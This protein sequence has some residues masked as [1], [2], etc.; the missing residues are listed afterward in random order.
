MQ[1]IFSHPQLPYLLYFFLSLNLTFFIGHLIYSMIVK[2]ESSNS[3]QIFSKLSIGLILIVFLT[4]LYW[5]SGNTIFWGWIIPFYF[6]FKKIKFKLKFEAIQIR[7]LIILQLFSLPILF[8]QYL[9][10]AKWGSFTLLPIDINN[11]AEISFYLK[12]GFECKYAALNSLDVK[13]IPSRS[14]YHYIDN[15]ITIFFNN[16]FRNTKI[17][18]I[19]IF[20]VFPIMITTFLSGLFS[21]LQNN[22]NNKYL[23][24]LVCILFL[25]F[26]PIDLNSIRE[27]FNDGS[28]LASNTVIFENVGFFFNTL[29]FSYHGQ[30][31]IPFYILVCWILLVYTKSKNKNLFVLFSFAPII[32]IGL[33]PAIIGGLSLFTFANYIK[34]K[35]LKESISSLNPIILTTV[36]LVVF[37][38]INGGY[39]IENQTKLNLFDSYLNAKGEILK[40]LYKIVYSSLFLLI[41]YFIF[42]IPFFAKKREGKIN[43]LLSITGYII[44]S[45]IAT[46]VVFEGFNSAQFLSYVLPLVNIVLMYVCSLYFKSKNI[47]AIL[48]CLLIIIGCS[49]NIK[50]TYYHT[51]NRRE[52]D[53]E[54]LHTKEFLSKVNELLIKSPNPKIG[55]FLS[56]QDFKLIPPGFWYGYYPCEFLLTFNYFQIYSLNFPNQKYSENSLSSNDFTTNHLR[57]ILPHNVKYNEYEK[58][59]PKIIKKMKI[60]YIIAKKSSRIPKTVSN[61]F[62]DSLR[63]TQSGDVIYRLF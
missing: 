24:F 40:V 58:V 33:A 3:L 1:I 14:P 43:G 15:W 35:K 11:H 44:I 21:V 46:R 42:L 18:Y 16:I 63:D 37:Y 12:N 50:R 20:V 48:Y 34:T 55:Y 56:Q 29:L 38:K 53:V 31:H 4:A 26:G 5:T 61:L 32:N 7:Q 28:L 45:G 52:I 54:K 23:L 30:K 59:L 6:I 62:S 25:F 8:F 13:N 2:Q 60:E 19:M 36:L 17:G 9:F 51:T 27:L 47:R 49:I 22:I 41:I 57:Y 10:F 39:D